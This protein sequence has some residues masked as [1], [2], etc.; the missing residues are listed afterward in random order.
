MSA[1]LFVVGALQASLAKDVG[2]SPWVHALHG[3]FAL[4]V[5]MLALLIAVRTWRQAVARTAV[6]RST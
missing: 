6:G 2:N 1:A 5:L 3:M 4:V